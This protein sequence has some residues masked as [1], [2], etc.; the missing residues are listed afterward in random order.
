[1]AENLV[2][3]CGTSQL[4]WPEDE[5]KQSLRV[6]SDASFFICISGCES[7]ELWD[8]KW[9]D[10]PAQS[11][12]WKTV[13]KQKLWCYD[14]LVF[15]HYKDKESTP[16]TL[17]P[18]AD[19]KTNIDDGTSKMSSHG[20]I[21][22]ITYSTKCNAT[23]IRCITVRCSMVWETLCEKNNM[24][25]CRGEVHPSKHLQVLETWVKAFVVG[26]PRS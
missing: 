20:T 18:P 6:I 13:Y 9:S 19:T 12:L 25:C 17:R 15:S 24:M 26:R 22:H 1:M 16:H 23:M 10:R 21:Q 14:V 11:L 3:V 8:Q 4:V 7:D 5:L 2:N